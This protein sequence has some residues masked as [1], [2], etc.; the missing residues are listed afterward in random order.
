VA[1]PCTLSDDLAGDDSGGAL[2]RGDNAWH[3]VTS[4]VPT[5]L[6]GFTVRAGVSFDSPSE[7]RGAGL[8][9]TA[10]ELTLRRM[11]FEHNHADHGAVAVLGGRILASD[12]RFLGNRADLS[13]AALFLASPDCEL[14]RVV[15]ADNRAP[16]GAALFVAGVSVAVSDSVFVGNEATQSGGAVGIGATSSGPQFEG[17]TWYGNSA[18]QGADL[19]FEGSDALTLRDCILWGGAALSGMAIHA[20]G[21]VD[22]EHCLLPGGLAGIAGEGVVGDLGGNGDDDPRFVDPTAGAGA[23][24]RWA[25]RDDGLIPAATSPAID[26]GARQGS[27]LRDVTGTA[28][29]QGAACDLGAYERGGAD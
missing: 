19:W 25:T 28:R 8:L 9:V 6:D 13:G 23:D 27:D 1:H 4:A 15:M 26:Q 22:L 5:I 21:P 24:R 29:P 12:C 7:S 17:C 14:R 10:G 18:I 11:V 3:V 2:Y 16:S 20:V